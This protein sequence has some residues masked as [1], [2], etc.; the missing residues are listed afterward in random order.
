MGEKMS[1]EEMMQ[2]MDQAAIQAEQFLRSI[3]GADCSAEDVLRWFK[4][5]YL[6][7]GHKRLGRIM[8]KLSKEYQ[9]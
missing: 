4:N 9:L 7:A 5:W 3:L 2:A 6:Q 1:K 8:V